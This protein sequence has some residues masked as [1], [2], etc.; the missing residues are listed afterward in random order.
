MIKFKLKCDKS[1]Y[2]DPVQEVTLELRSDGQ[3]NIDVVSVDEKGDII[4]YLVAFSKYGV[5]NLHDRVTRGRGFRLN[6]YDNII[7]MSNRGSLN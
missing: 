7:V 5:L 4:T 3:G 1:E 6:N 2:V